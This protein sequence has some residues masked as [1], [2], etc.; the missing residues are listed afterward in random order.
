M[1]LLLY[2]L[3]LF[4]RLTVTFVNGIDLNLQASHFAFAENFSDGVI[5]IGLI[6]MERQDP[7]P[8]IFVAS[9]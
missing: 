5:G 7:L 2:F 8:P 9:L 6:D 1:A 3:R 4:Q